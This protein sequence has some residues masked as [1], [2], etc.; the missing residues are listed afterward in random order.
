[1]KAEKAITGASRRRLFKNSIE[2]V[3]NCYVEYPPLTDTPSDILAEYLVVCLEAFD[4]AQLAKRVN[5]PHWLD[6][7]SE[8]LL[9]YPGTLDRAYC[10]D[11][12][13]DHFWSAS[14]VGEGTYCVNC[15]V[16]LEDL[17]DRPPTI[18][19]KVLWKDSFLETISEAE[20]TVEKAVEDINFC[21]HC[22]ERIEMWQKAGVEIRNEMRVNR[23]KA[24]ELGKALESVITKAKL[25]EA[26]EQFEVA[27]S[28]YHLVSP[29]EALDLLDKSLKKTEDYYKK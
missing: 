25:D 27:M 29:K 19:E 12:L 6:D 20:D 5:D 18:D 1:M 24:E 15:P 4:T 9:K 23:E 21:N 7:G 16:T 8:D 10:G 14:T 11:L 28:A 26:I 13:S 2:E 22:L 3:L 17:N